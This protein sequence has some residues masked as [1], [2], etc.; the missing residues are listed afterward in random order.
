MRAVVI[1]AGLAGLAAGEALAEA[2]VEVTT[3]EA[4]ERVGGR[5]WS[6]RL[7][8]GCV[9][10]RGA[11]FVT[12]G[13]QLLPET[14]A[15]LGLRLAPM[16]T[17][18]SRREPRGGIG[19][20][21]AALDQGVS[22]VAA[23]VAAGDGSGRTVSELLAALPL[24]DGVRELIACRIEVTYAHPAE[25]IAAEAVRDAGH[26]FAPDQGR[27]I[28]G[29]NGQLAERLCCGRLLT[30][31]PARSVAAAGGRLLVNGEL[32]AD[33]VVVAV[34]APAARSIAFDPPLPDSKQRA[35]A[36]VAYGHAAKLAVPL[37]SPA[38][39]SSVLSVPGRFWTWTALDGDGRQ[40]PVAAC[41]AGSAP[42]LERLGV[43]QGAGR[44]LEQLAALSPELDLDTGGALLTTWPEGAY[45]TRERGG[46]E[47][48]L[49]R[50]LGA[51]AFAG[52]HT[53]DTW[54]ATMEGALRS[55][56]RAAAELL[57]SSG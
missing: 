16:G 42:A 1:G 13:Y 40:A 11:E 56:R 49:A 47:P 28:D 32:E 48:E 14:A 20:G 6:Q 45:S 43:Q 34:P 23:A 22:A 46:F 7:A 8:N 52:E 30:S 37:R 33:A 57:A 3:L 15:R 17:S 29:G 38:P 51:I 41:F 18:F 12:D 50:P 9:V 19:A 5:V 55:G 21:G 26:L 36:A 53:E 31:T 35:L 44:W 39:P 54:F 27:R 25:R 2:G 10:E 4:R 24:A